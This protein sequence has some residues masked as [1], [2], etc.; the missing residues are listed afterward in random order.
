M[1][2]V[3]VSTGINCHDM[4]NA[5][6]RKISIEES[7]EV[8]KEVL[9]GRVYTIVMT[10]YIMLPILI[11]FSSWLRL[12]IAIP[13]T[14]IILFGAFAII[15][16]NWNNR[17][18]GTGKHV[19]PVLIIVFVISLALVYL[20]GIGGYVAQKRDHY[21]RNAIFDTLVN[22]K[23]PVLTDVLQAD[24]SIIRNGMVYYIG[25]WLPAA[26][27]GKVFGLEAGYFFQFV[28]AVIG[29]YLTYLSIVQIIKKIAVWPMLVF[30]FFSGLDFAAVVLF[31]NY[32]YMHW[33]AHIEWW[34]NNWQF[35]SHVTQL[36]WVFNQAIYGW[37]ILLFIM[38]Q[39]NSRTMVPILACG[40]IEST[41]PF[42]GI[43]PFMLYF[44]TKNG[45]AEYK[46]HGSVKPIF[47][48]LFTVAN[49]LVGGVI[50]IISFLYLKT[51][52]S[53]QIVG[54]SFSAVSDVGTEVTDAVGTIVDDVAAVTSTAVDVASQYTFGEMLSDVLIFLA[55]EIGIYALII[56][57]LYWKKPLFWISVVFLA[58]CPFVK[59]GSAADF[60]MRASI[61]SLVIL[62]IL[63]M[64]SLTK[65]KQEK[66]KVRLIGLIVA[67]VVGSVT[68]IHEI[69]NTIYNTNISIAK[70]GEV[71]RD[72]IG[73]ANIRTSSGNFTGAT[74]DS[75]FFKY[76]SKDVED[77]DLLD[78][79]GNTV[80]R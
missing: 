8:S 55:I 1:K 54:D 73:E 41:F 56:G 46:E 33:T 52:F 66:L 61:P 74:E 21:W 27:F 69:V 45:M 32:S 11:F 62:C 57:K 47:K 14:L 77:V 75:L 44:M 4:D 25:F 50:G 31:Q 13:C 78:V 34:A 80:E 42:I 60:T 67:L 9:W 19:I 24:G 23:W 22:V 28:W 53:S 48:N 43:I 59:V 5:T 15:R 3:R 2:I 76:F 68:P 58:V 70:Y 26:V 65:C 7:K 35:S 17:F 38:L 30:T 49:I 36:C 51:N 40:L 79:K 10:V 12:C 20:S 6:G 64:K 16:N 37:L 71:K 63:V 72:S 39:K 29:V 18:E